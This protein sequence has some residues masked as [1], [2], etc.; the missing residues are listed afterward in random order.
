V[1]WVGLRAQGVKERKRRREERR[2]R[3]KE[4]REKKNFFFSFRCGSLFFLRHFLEVFKQEKKNSA[5][6]SL[7]RARRA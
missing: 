2:R 6:S 4:S 1:R 7:G 3:R 5:R